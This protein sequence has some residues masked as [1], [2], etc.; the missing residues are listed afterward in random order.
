MNFWSTPEPFRFAR[1]IVPSLFAQYT[2]ASAESAA[3]ARDSEGEGGERERGAA[4]A[5]H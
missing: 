5:Q 3:S 2:K 1:P 4:Y